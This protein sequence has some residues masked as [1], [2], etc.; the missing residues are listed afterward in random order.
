MATIE[1]ADSPQAGAIGLSAYQK[2]RE[3]RRRH[4]LEWDESDFTDK[5]GNFIQKKKRGRMICDQKANSIADMAAVLSRLGAKQDVSGEGKEDQEGT[6]GLVGEWSGEKVVVR[7]RDV[8]DAEFAETWGENVEHG[9][10]E[11]HTNNRDP[12]RSRI[13]WGKKATTGTE[14]AEKTLGR[15]QEAEKITL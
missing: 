3:Y 12:T 11:M 6:I 8:N 4:E 5:E 9:V 13:G 14:N 15:E 1:F 10:L 2:L 7:W